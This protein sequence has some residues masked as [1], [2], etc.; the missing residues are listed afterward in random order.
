MSQC[1]SKKHAGSHV[2]CPL[3][4]ILLRWVA[5]LC[6]CNNKNLMFSINI[7]LTSWLNYMHVGL[8]ARNLALLHAIYRGSNILLNLL[9]ELRKRD[10]MRDLQ[11]FK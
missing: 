3:K 11:R 6:I 8:I 9:M 4:H 7:I 10:K 2:V 5:L 1:C